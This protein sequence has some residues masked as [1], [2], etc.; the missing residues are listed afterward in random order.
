MVSLH[1]TAGNRAHITD[2]VRWGIVVLHGNAVVTC[3]A[4]KPADCVPVSQR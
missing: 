4:I 3:V 1:V 2:V